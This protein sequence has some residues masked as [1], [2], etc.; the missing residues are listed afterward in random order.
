MGTFFSFIWEYLKAFSKAIGRWLVRYPLAAAAAA[1][2]IVGAVFLLLMGK[3]VQIGGLLGK[4]FGKKKVPN[5]RGVPPEGRVD[6]DGKP[7]RPGESDG[8]GW[9]QAPAIEEI[10]KPGLFD[11][12]DTITIV[13]PEKGDV[14]IDLPEGVKNSD[15]REV[16]EIEPDV[17]EV[18]NNDKGADTKKLLNVLGKK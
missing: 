16:V 12:P 17:Y 10:K 11:D 13:H 4:L 8:K 1:A 2:V 9:V 7:I 14:K 3:N 5:A 15:V 18:R 6:D